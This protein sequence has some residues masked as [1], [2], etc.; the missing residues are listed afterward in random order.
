MDVQPVEYRR[1]GF[2]ISTD[3]RHLDI[4]VIFNFLAHDSYW[5]KNI[6]LEIVQKS[7]RNSLCFGVYADSSETDHR[8]QVGFARVMTDC[9]TFAYLADVFILPEFRG[10]GLGKW[11]V[12]C[13]LAHP[14]LQHLRSFMLATS[15]AHGLYAGFGF[16]PLA[17]PEK[18]MQKRVENPYGPGSAAR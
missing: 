18:F 3:P 5:A 11:L 7:I 10:R 14:D 4:D 9:A 2:E 12:E 1:D 8:V 16:K 17:Q 15:D 6:P 13:I